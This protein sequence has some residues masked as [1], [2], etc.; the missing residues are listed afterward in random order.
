MKFIVITFQIYCFDITS[1]DGLGKVGNRFIYTLT[2]LVSRL[3]K[4][5]NDLMA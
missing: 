4:E 3:A 1:D 5:A 2:P